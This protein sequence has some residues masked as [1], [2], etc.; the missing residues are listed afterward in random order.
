MNDKS[1]IAIFIRN[2][3]IINELKT[4]L[5]LKNNIINSKS[6]VFNVDKNIIIINNC[7]N[8]I[9]SLTIINNDFSIKRLIK[10]V[11][12]LKIFI[13]SIITIFYKL[14]N[15][16]DLLINK[17]FMF[18]S[19]R[20]DRL[21]QKNDIF[22][23]I[24]DVH[25]DVMQ[26]RNIINSTIYIFKNNKINVIQEYEKKC[27]LIREKNV[28]FAINFEFHKSTQSNWFKR[29]MKI[30]IVVVV[31][32]IATFFVYQKIVKFTTITN[33]IDVELITFIDI[34]IYDELSIVQ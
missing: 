23:H 9:I 13:N 14:K 30:K 27:Y 6:I 19:Q 11:D 4:K 15:K 32:E 2:V 29:I 12:D 1:A 3:N 18:I 24:V 16:F 33:V 31:V 21:K 10:A 20:F 28:H 25:I 22:F 34:T 17:N 8:F 26:I 5:L 7:Q